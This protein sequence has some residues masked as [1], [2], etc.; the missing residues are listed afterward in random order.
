M[1][2]KKTGIE[3]E[4]VIPPESIPAEYTKEQIVKSDKYKNRKDLLNA[5]LEDGRNYTIEA[6]EQRIKAFMKGTVN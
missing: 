6:V 1:T 2:S 5:L 4:T 3:T